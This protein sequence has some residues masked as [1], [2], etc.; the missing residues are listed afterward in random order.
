[1]LPASK[2][3]VAAIFESF[4]N[5]WSVECLKQLMTEMHIPLADMQQLRLCVT[6][7][8][9]HPEDLNRGVPECNPILERDA[10]SSE[11]I[12]SG[13]ARLADVAAGLKSFQLIP[14]D[15]KGQAILKGVDLF[16]HMVRMACTQP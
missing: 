6:L 2:H 10:E 11:Q 14:K 3:R 5:K 13:A 1:M 16:N 9:E 4:E 7:A 8:I 15:D 12:A